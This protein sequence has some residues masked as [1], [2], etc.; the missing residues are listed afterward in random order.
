MPLLTTRAKH[1][2]GPN[3]VG[4]REDQSNSNGNEEIQ[5]GSTGNQRNP[6][7]PSWTTRA[8]YG[9]DAARLRPQKRKCSTHL[10]SISN[11]VQSSTKGSCRMG[12]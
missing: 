2:L 9:R 11:A 6:M 3:N 10:E 4:D 8:K 1:L 5:L 7:D 12:I